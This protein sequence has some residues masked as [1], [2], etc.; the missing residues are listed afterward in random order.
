MG[1]QPILH[2]CLNRDMYM[3]AWGRVQLLHF[4]ALARYKIPNASQAQAAS[5]TGDRL[6]FPRNHR[7]FPPAWLGCHVLPSTNSLCSFPMPWFAPGTP[8]LSGCPS[9]KGTNKYCPSSFASL[10][11]KWLFSLPS[12]LPMLLQ[13]LVFFTL[14]IIMNFFNANPTSWVTPLIINLYSIFHWLWLKPITSTHSTTLFPITPIVS[15]RNQT[16]KL[17]NRN[18]SSRGAAFVVLQWGARVYTALSYQGHGG[19]TEG[20][21]TAQITTAQQPQGSSLGAKTPLLCRLSNT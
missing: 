15:S 9:R 5:S 6:V 12:Q 17:R 7:A 8:G 1:V 11:G 10:C 14:M 18:R 2:R 3:N 20:V 21:W 19:C 4:P 16:K 13:S